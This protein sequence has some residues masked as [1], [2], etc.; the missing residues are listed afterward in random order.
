MASGLRSMASSH[1]RNGGSSCDADS[2]KTF[3]YSRYCSGTICSRVLMSFFACSAAAS[4]V[5]CVVRQKAMS[6]SL[7][8]GNAIKTS[9]EGERDEGSQDLIKRRRETEGSSDQKEGMRSLSFVPSA[10]WTRGAY[11][12]PALKLALGA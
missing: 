5:D 1:L 3:R 4:L 12:W 11:R 7:G 10:K 8:E 6:E 2:S 9:S